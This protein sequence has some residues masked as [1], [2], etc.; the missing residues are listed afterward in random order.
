MLA[1]GNM[2]YLCCV[3]LIN[4]TH[5]KKIVLSAMVVCGLLFATSVSVVAQDKKDAPKTECCK[6]KQKDACKKDKEACKKDKS[7]CDKSK[8]TSCCKKK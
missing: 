2:A 7:G 3:S 8:K 5:M 4:L 6:K 1:F